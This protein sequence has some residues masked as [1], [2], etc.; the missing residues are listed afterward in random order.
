M[1]HDTIT[2]TLHRQ[3]NAKTHLDLDSSLDQFL[4]LCIVKISRFSLRSATYIFLLFSRDTA[5]AGK[6][7]VAEPEKCKVYLLCH[8][9][10]GAVISKLS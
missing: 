10:N 5:H 7:I 8:V 2:Q 6:A 4:I 3:N 9:G 1:G